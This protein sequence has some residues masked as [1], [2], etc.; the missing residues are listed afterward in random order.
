LLILDLDESLVYGSETPLDRDADFQVGP[1]HVYRRPYLDDFL[2][3]AFEWF[4]VAVWS[5]ASGAYVRGV[6]EHVFQDRPS[7]KFV[8]PRD[9]CTQ[10]LD[11]ELLDYYWLK[12][13]KKVKRLGYALERVLMVDDSPEKLQRQYGNH[14]QVRPFLG[15][16]DDS[17][18]R[19]VLPFLETLRTAANLRTVEKRFW[20]RGR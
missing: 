8:W 7:L 12:N 14:L 16:T 4:E 11:P 3:N 1:Y 20:R 17:E 15:S 6:V 2:S 9:R 13:L 18:L 5:S 19:D 10:C